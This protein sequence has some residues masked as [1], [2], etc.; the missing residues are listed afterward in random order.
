[1][2]TA[3]KLPS[4][5][6]RCKVFAG[7]KYING[8]KK[9][10]YRS[11]TAASKREAE[12]MAAAWLVDRKK[13]TAQKT[14]GELLKEYIEV[15]TGVLSV[16][17]L[18]MYQTL[19]NNSY[20]GIEDIRADRIASADMQRW[21]SA[22]SKV[23]APSSIRLEY[24][25]LIAALK[26]YGVNTSF[27]VTFPQQKK[28]LIEFPSAEELRR[29][30]DSAR[31]SDLWSAIVLSRFYGLRIGEICGLFGS[32]LHGDEIY[33]H[34]VAVDAPGGEIIKDTPKTS[35][36]TRSVRISGEILE[37]MQNMK[38]NEKLIKCTKSA[39]RT[40][41]YHALDAAGVKRIRF[42]LLRHM[43]ATS[44]AEMGIPDIY[45]AKIGGWDAGSAT[46]K[47]IYQ[48]AQA[49]GLDHSFDVINERMHHDIHHDVH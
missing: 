43:F 15:K 32:D 4:G 44:C 39:L 2:A 11:F 28:E 19:V 22:R 20:Y 31:G 21:I 26:M 16:T 3:K 48:N 46:L 8:E 23:V 17:T 42:H 34:Q 49:E 29:V 40:Q 6:W 5:N 47:R 27:R 36:S 33:I 1:M 35:S 37:K 14:V 18:K 10:D 12:A 13:P 45:T 24:K 30:L 7:Y 41:W 25:I 38:T 9:R